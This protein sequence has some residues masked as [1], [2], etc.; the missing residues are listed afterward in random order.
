MSLSRAIGNAGSSQTGRRKKRLLTSDPAAVY[1]GRF[2]FSKNIP[3]NTLQSHCLPCLCCASHMLPSANKSSWSWLPGGR[4]PS[5]PE[6]YPSATQS[7]AAAQSSSHDLTGVTHHPPPFPSYGQSTPFCEEPPQLWP[8]EL[9]DLPPSVA[10]DYGVPVLGLDP[11]SAPLYDASVPPEWAADFQPPLPPT[12]AVP[13]Q[14]TVAPFGLVDPAFHAIPPQPESMTHHISTGY[15]NFGDSSETY[16]GMLQA[17]GLAVSVV[18]DSHSSVA[19]SNQSPSRKRRPSMHLDLSNLRFEPSMDS[20][21]SAGSKRFRA[22][23]SERYTPLTSGELYPLAKLVQV[24][25][26]RSG[27]LHPSLDLSWI[28][29]LN[30]SAI[31]P[32]PIHVRYVKIKQNGL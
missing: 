32:P 7:A 5:A 8:P 19:G 30:A 12:F 20:V 10:T 29:Q 26:Q 16:L 2:F 31:T 11:W 18:G 4:R 9:V 25:D 21:S 28:S 3:T 15:G 22:T 23:P 6:P 17:E 24:V 13:V 1:P 14:A 27:F